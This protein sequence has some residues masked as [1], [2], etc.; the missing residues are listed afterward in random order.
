M[1]KQVIDLRSYLRNTLNGDNFSDMT[2]TAANLSS[3]GNFQKNVYSDNS[4]TI[5][6]ELY[7]EN[8]ERYVIVGESFV[9]DGSVVGP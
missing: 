8:A 2:T 9:G 4:F 7:N 3:V 6:Y 5:S 1:P